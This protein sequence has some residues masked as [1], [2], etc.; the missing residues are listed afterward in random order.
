MSEPA[1]RKRITLPPGWTFD[2][3][4][5][6][7][8]Q[9]E[10]YDVEPRIEHEEATSGID[11]F[12]NIDLDLDGLPELTE[13]DRAALERLGSPEDFIARIIARSM[14]QQQPSPPP[15]PTL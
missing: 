4:I 14:D 5:V 12:D 15:E 10:L 9:P 1:R 6:W 11:E 13:E 7:A 3:L 2:D 8:H